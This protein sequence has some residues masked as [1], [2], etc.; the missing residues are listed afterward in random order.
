MMTP[1]NMMTSSNF[2]LVKNNPII[3]FHNPA[4]FLI[5][6]YFTLC[7]VSLVYITLCELLRSRK[8]SRKNVWKNIQYVFGHCTIGTLG[9]F[10]L[11]LLN[12]NGSCFSA[13]SS[14]SASTSSS[15]STTST[16]CIVVHVTPTNNSMQNNFSGYKYKRNWCS[17]KNL[18]GLFSVLLQIQGISLDN[19]F[20]LS[21]RI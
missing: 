2:W 5:R 4:K 8:T 3:I 13:T 19:P 6:Q 17:E 20:L 10:L 1:S 15:N 16:F 12:K 9:F 7:T 14:R 18:F 11:L 21:D